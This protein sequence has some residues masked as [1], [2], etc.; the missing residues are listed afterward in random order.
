IVV[1]EIATY[2]TLNLDHMIQFYLLMRASCQLARQYQEEILRIP[3]IKIKEMAEEQGLYNWFSPPRRKDT[4]KT[5]SG[6]GSIHKEPGPLGS[7][8]TI[9]AADP[10]DEAE[11]R[12]EWDLDRQ[13]AIEICGNGSLKGLK[14]NTF[15]GMEADWNNRMSSYLN[16]L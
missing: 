4:T 5:H 7:Q 10:Q 11:W 16:S 1:Y 8:E 15:G 9:L 12:T 2:Q 3:F 6:S 13:K 14:D